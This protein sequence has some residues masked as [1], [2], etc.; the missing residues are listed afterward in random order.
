M[1]STQI[2]GKEEEKEGERQE[3]FGDRGRATQLA[4]NYD[5]EHDRDGDQAEGHREEEGA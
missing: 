2:Q 5:A 4:R 3:R 1:M